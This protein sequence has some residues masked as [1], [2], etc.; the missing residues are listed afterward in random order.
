MADACANVLDNQQQVRR[1]AQDATAG[2][3]DGHLKLINLFDNQLFVPNF[4]LSL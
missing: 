3:Q 1:G 4:R 2:E